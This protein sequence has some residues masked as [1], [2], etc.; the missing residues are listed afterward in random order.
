MNCE[1]ATERMNGCLDGE[2]DPITSQTIEQ[3][4]RGCA[5]SKAYRL[6]SRSSQ[7]KRRTVDSDSEILAAA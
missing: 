5:G 2:L 1:E 6:S 3:H 7:D 4:L